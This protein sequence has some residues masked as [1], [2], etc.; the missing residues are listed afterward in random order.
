MTLGQRL[1]LLRSKAGVS[2]AAV[3]ANVSISKGYL[4]QLETSVVTNP[5]LDMLQ[6]LARYYGVP[7]ASLLGEHPP[8]CDLRVQ[9]LASLAL[10][11]DDADIK[12]LEHFARRLGR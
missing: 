4:S 2:L 9:V 11:C 8:H 5:S 10:G 7:V 12:L 1:S 3:C 6:G